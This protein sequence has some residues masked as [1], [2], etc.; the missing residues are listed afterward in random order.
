MTTEKIKVS[1]ICMFFFPMISHFSTL[2]NCFYQISSYSKA[3]VHI[4]Y[5]R[6]RGGG[7]PQDFHQKTK[8][9]KIGI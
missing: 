1:T 6:Q 4:I 8:P 5:K 7:L 9:Y 2:E 3:Y